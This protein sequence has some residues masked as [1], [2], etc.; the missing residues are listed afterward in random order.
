AYAQANLI[1]G[2]LQVLS[3][4]STAVVEDTIVQ[5][6]GQQIIY[7]GTAKNSHIGAGSYQL[8]SG[9]ALNTFLYNGAFQQVYAG[10]GGDNV[11][12]RDTTVY[13]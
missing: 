7:A 13:T 9:L 6:G 5:N 12:D 11:A 4:T 3:V 1:D 10:Q 2:G 8:T